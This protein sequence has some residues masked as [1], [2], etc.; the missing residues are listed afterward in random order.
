MRR[1]FFL[2][3]LSAMINEYALAQ[4]TQTQIKLPPTFAEPIKTELK[5]FFELS[6]GEMEDLLKGEVISQGKVTS[7]TKQEQEMKLTV[8]GVHPRNCTRA[9][10]K[11]SQYENYHQYI[12]FIKKSEY[13]QQTQ[14]FS[15]MVDHAL[16]PFPMV[17]GFKIAR[18]TK[19]GNYQFLFED[20]F[21]KGLTGQLIIRDVGKFCLMGL[22][23]DW[24]GPESPIPNTIFGTFVQTVG[25]IGLERLIRVSLF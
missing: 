6:E 11:L 4:G 12:D 22:K 14:K 13:N 7:P 16:L 21:L 15:F 20:G 9:M 2:I 8:A 5:P 23:S 19:A 25:K 10:R 17:V 18:I 3:F 1:R 24:R